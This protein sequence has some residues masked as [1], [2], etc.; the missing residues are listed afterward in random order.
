[1][2]PPSPT[3]RSTQS[4]VDVPVPADGSFKDLDVVGQVLSILVNLSKS[5]PA[6]AAASLTAGTA[7]LGRMG[8]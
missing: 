2:T 6:F 3:T 5:N 7:A 1:M 8:S 4:V